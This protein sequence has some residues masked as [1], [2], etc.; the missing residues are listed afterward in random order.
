MSFH[1]LNALLDGR[2]LVHDIE[3]SF[4]A[5]ESCV[6]KIICFFDMSCHMTIHLFFQWLHIEIGW[7]IKGVNSE[8]AKIKNTLIKELKTLSCPELSWRCTSMSNWNSAS[9]LCSLYLFWCPS[10]WLPIIVPL[11]VPCRNPCCV[12]ETLSWDLQKVEADAWFLQFYPVLD[13]AG[14]CCNVSLLRLRT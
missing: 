11:Q 13:P 1:V 4:Y 3:L 10:V 14:H 2:K 6:W 12:Q 5:R 7:V 9:G 8:S